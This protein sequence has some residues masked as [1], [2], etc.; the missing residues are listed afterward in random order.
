MRFLKLAV[1]SVIVIFIILSAMGALLP[2][3]ILVS[4]A[5]DI[6]AGREAIKDEVFRLNNWGHWMTNAK[7]EAAEHRFDSTSSVLHIGPTEVRPV[8]VT[9]SSFV[10]NWSAAKPMKAT[11]RIISHP[12]AE[13]LYTVQ[14]QMEQEVGWFFWHKFASITKDEIWGASM[15]K[16]LDNLKTRLEESR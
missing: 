10:T 14:W 3:Q 11:F 12:S 5:V 16:S 7:G 4:R 13:S 15:E 1:I 9:D 8:S 2:S 6:R